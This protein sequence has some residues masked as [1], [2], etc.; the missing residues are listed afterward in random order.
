MKDEYAK[1]VRALLKECQALEE[2]AVRLG[3]AEEAVRNADLSGD[4]RLQI[5][6]RDEVV[7]SATFAGRMERS[8]TAFAWNL[9]HYEEADWGQDKL[10]RA[11][12]W[13]SEDAPLVSTIKRADIERIIVQMEEVFTR[14]NWWLYPVHIMRFRSGIV[15]GEPAESLRPHFDAFEEE[16]RRRNGRR[17]AYV[18]HIWSVADARLGDAERAI[19]RLLE[20]SN[21]GEF[22]EPPEYPHRT[23]A[24]LALALCGADRRGEALAHFQRAR[25]LCSGN[26]V[27]LREVARLL[28]CAPT[29]A[30]DQIPA[31]IERHLVWVHDTMDH[32]SAMFWYAAAAAALA[33][34]SGRNISPRLPEPDPRF[35]DGEPMPAGELAEAF[36]K[37]ALALADAFDLRNG[38]TT[39]RTTVAAIR[40]GAPPARLFHP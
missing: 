34:M 1:R 26:Q 11:F 29:L 25:S 8:M 33:G 36:W 20:P 5:D 19:D 2:G 12:Q 14:N 10:W 40:D 16:W 13:V 22:D 7:A 9:A 39:W 17:S 30:P 32:W 18:Q 31:L 27:F 3:L 23:H 37:E 4:R 24:F 6:A 28:V 15:F 35:G 38:N 21:R